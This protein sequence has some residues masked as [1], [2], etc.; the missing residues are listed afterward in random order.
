ML[1]TLGNEGNANQNSL[2]DLMS[3]QSEW[4]PL[5]NHLQQMLERAGG[6]ESIGGAA[7]W[8]SPSEN[9]CGAL[10]KG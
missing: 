8:S 10:F 2:W 9:P 7:N 5:T 1:I 4:L 3:P 6:K